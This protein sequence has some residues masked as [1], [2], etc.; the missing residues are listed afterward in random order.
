ME[1]SSG[2]AAKAQVET[3]GEELARARQMFWP[4]KAQ[5]RPVDLSTGLRLSHPPDYGVLL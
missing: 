2:R 4:L 3:I 5:E 1:T